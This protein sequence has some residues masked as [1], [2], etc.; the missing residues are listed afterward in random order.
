MTGFRPPPPPPKKKD[1]WD[2]SKHGQQAGGT[3][4]TGM[5]SFYLLTVA[6]LS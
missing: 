4:P 1:I 3:Q 5:H 6:K 2:T